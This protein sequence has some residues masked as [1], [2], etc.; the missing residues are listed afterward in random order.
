MLGHLERV[1][2]VEGFKGWVVSWASL[3]APGMN[4][5]WFSEWGFGRGG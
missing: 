4:G 2:L 5:I 1:V 3:A